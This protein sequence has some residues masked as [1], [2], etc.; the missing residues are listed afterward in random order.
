MEKNSTDK[1]CPF[2]AIAVKRAD[3]ARCLALYFT[4]SQTWEQ[5]FRT[6][7]V[8]IPKIHVLHWYFRR[9]EVS[10]GP[11]FIYR[12]SDFA[13]LKALAIAYLDGLDDA[14][15]SEPESTDY[16]LESLSDCDRDQQKRSLQRISNAISG[17]SASW[18][19]SPAADPELVAEV[20]RKLRLP[21]GPPLL[22]PGRGQ[23]LDFLR[24]A[25]QHYGWH[26][27][28]MGAAAARAKAREPSAPEVR[29]Y[30][31][32]SLSDHDET[33]QRAALKRISDAINGMFPSPIENPREDPELVAEVRL[34]L[35]VPEGELSAEDRGRVFD[36][37]R[38]ALLHYGRHIFDIDA[39]AARAK[40]GEL[41]AP[42][43]THEVVDGKLVRKIVVTGSDEDMSGGWYGKG[44][45][46]GYADGV[47]MA[48]ETPN[49]PT[50]EVL[51]DNDALC[52]REREKQAAKD[53]VV[54][55]TKTYRAKVRGQASLQSK[56]DAG[57]E[58]DRLLQ[59]LEALESPLPTRE[60]FSA[61]HHALWT[62]SGA[63]MG[64]QHWADALRNVAKQLRNP[65]RG[66]MRKA[67]ETGALMEHS[68][69]KAANEL[70]CQA[71]ELEA[72]S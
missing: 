59:R 49:A 25:F 55:A 21:V 29:G 45:D 60:E 65:E 64:E 37:L 42:D 71:D 52:G 68:L 34:R 70:E 27:S 69:G 46:K 8:S 1:P 48:T 63:S 7:S 40:A 5:S 39:A 44:Y 15:P 19:K 28:D 4:S 13:G 66:P 30:E 54:E 57:D 38:G 3:E 41:S 51:D 58:V 50:S 31:L 18:E 32:E 56:D 22:Q 17:M 53:A 61:R 2:T 33:R 43:E 62:H 35:G 67:V 26:T 24:G 12:E 72:R 6:A 36:F 9:Y 47:G 10:G 16:R 20:Q 23:V 14:E 11:G